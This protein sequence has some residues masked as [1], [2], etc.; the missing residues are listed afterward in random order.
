MSIGN[1]VRQLRAVPTLAVLFLLCLSIDKHGYDVAK[2][3]PESNPSMSRILPYEVRNDNKSKPLRRINTVSS[4]DVMTIA[5]ASQRMENAMEE[6]LQIIGGLLAGRT[7][8][9]ENTAVKLKEERNNRV[10]SPV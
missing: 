4:I 10:S 3:L 9:L 2:I 7:A 8:L 1:I 5:A 6:K